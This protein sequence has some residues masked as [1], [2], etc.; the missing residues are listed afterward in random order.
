MAPSKGATITVGGLVVLCLFG[1]LAVPSTA[2]ASCAASTP[3]RRL[4]WADVVF[5][6]RVTDIDVEPSAPNAVYFGPQRVTFAVDRGWKG[7]VTAVMVVTLP[8]GTA[9]LRAERG[10]VYLVYAMGDQPDTLQTNA[11][12]GTEP[13]GV[14]GE[15]LR[16]LGTGSPPGEPAPPGLPPTGD[17]M[18]VPS[19]WPLVAAG[20]LAAG[21]AALAWRRVH[22]EGRGA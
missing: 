1:I 17:G 15:D 19:P 2:L 4:A 8:R 7:P 12:L 6:G 18:T 13:I 16:F 14:A 5:R 3:A 9:D 22:R 11:C 21:V 10:E 20:L